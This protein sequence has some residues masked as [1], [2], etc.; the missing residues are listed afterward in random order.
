MVKVE[1]AS[2]TRCV[3]FGIISQ[4]PCS[5]LPL[6]LATRK[7][8]NRNNPNCTDIDDKRNPLVTKSRIE[9]SLQS[10]SLR[11]RKLL[12]SKCYIQDTE[13]RNEKA[14]ISRAGFATTEA[15][16]FWQGHARSSYLLKRSLCLLIVTFSL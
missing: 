5:S 11:P 14:R 4:T 7:V 10:F 15:S 1:F 12:N 8:L 6:Q 3:S 16:D 13:F 2:I 9:F